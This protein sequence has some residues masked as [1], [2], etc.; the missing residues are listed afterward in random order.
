MIIRIGRGGGVGK[1]RRWMIGWMG[2]SVAKEN[3][4][5]QIQF[6]P[7]THHIIM[8]YSPMKCLD[9]ANANAMHAVAHAVM[10]FLERCPFTRNE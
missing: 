3:K 2:I 5:Q 8:P 7:L 4:V 10:T 6:R 9:Y 1:E